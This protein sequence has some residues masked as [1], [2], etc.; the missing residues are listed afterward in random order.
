MAPVQPMSKAN[1]EARRKLLQTDFRTAANGALTLT[2]VSF[3]TE[4]LEA[5]NS[6]AASP[7]SKYPEVAMAPR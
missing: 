1:F 2:R 7:I 6:G 3:K 4:F 5:R